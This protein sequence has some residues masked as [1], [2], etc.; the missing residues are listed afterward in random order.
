M[1]ELIAKPFISQKPKKTNS[2]W[3]LV[4][5]IFYKLTC[6]LR[7]REKESQSNSSQANEFVEV[8]VVHC[9]P[10]GN[11]TYLCVN[12]G[13]VSH[14]SYSKVDSFLR[15]EFPVLEQGG[16]LE[17]PQSGGAIRLTMAGGEFC[18]N[19][20]RSAAAYLAHEFLNSSE[21]TGLDVIADFSKIEGCQ[22]L[23]LNFSLE[24]SGTNKLLS[25]TAKYSGGRL[26]V[27]NEVPLPDQSFIR[28]ETL[29]FGGKPHI[30]WVVSLEGITHV[31][32]DHS[33]HPWFD[34]SDSR[35]FLRRAQNRFELTDR[36]AIGLILFQ[37]KEEANHWAIDPV[38]F[39]R[40]I[41]SFV[42]ETSCGSGSC[43]LGVLLHYLSE[44]RVMSI[45]VEQPSGVSIEC[46]TGLDEREELFAFI[47][48][49]VELK[50]IY[51]LR[52]SETSETG[53]Y[54]ALASP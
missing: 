18:G 1:K 28:K 31:L 39:V 43:A 45:S 33:K 16:F 11:D 32:L 48:G 36:A 51:Q 34:K 38:I 27:K 52:L 9:W 46:C 49:V 54:I 41:S 15:N 23:G 20:V 29:V 8:S 47:G 24:S 13:E 40:E 26:F 21:R 44:N 50:D 4:S 6:C 37:Q 3:L 7:G 22:D 42:D 19:A 25:A 30:V 10:G 14:G 12:Q 53:E 5:I 35:D 17:S 2:F